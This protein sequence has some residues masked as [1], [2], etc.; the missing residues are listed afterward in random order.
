MQ[1]A[2]P[3]AGLHKLLFTLLIIGI[4]VGLV[5]TKSELFATPI[6]TIAQVFGVSV[7]T[8]AQPAQISNANVIDKII[9]QTLQEKDQALKAQDQILRKNE[10]DLET[11]NRQNQMQARWE[12]FT[13]EMSRWL[14]LAVMGAI[15][16]VAIV[17]S[18]TLGI[19]GIQ[20][21]Q[22]RLILAQAQAQITPQPRSRSTNNWQDQAWRK[23]KIEHARQNEQAMRASSL[24]HAHPIYIPPFY[25]N[26][27]EL[28]SWED[29]RREFKKPKHG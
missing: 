6:S 22:S 11:Q 19:M 23:K 26:E 18:I 17:I 9:E 14:N 1:P 2:N 28:I 3:F 25:A 20:F 13:L 12:A 24:K 21:G 4:G 8:A 29:I 5:L 16:V 15:V 10:L 27:E 7:N